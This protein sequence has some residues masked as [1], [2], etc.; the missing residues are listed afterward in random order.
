MG[1][2]SDSVKAHLYLALCLKVLSDQA[3]NYF[4]YQDPKNRAR[5]EIALDHYTWKI[6]GTRQQ[7]DGPLFNWLEQL[8]RGFHVC[9][10]SKEELRDRT[11]RE[12]EKLR[13]QEKITA[14]LVLDDLL[15]AAQQLEDDYAAAKAKS[16]EIAAEWKRR[17]AELAALPQLF[18]A[19]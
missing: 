3:V 10:Y 2:L 8:E 14:P 1:L 4:P 6:S 15:H 9:A 16:L 18:I 13:E 7:A 12:C 11:R 17:Y 5:V 19:V